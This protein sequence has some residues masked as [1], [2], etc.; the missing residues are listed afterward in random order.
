MNWRMFAASETASMEVMGSMVEASVVQGVGIQ[1]QRVSVR[2][3]I[4]G[5]QGIMLNIT[6]EHSHMAELTRGLK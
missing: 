1:E 6:C 2:E 5:P 4:D 3:Q